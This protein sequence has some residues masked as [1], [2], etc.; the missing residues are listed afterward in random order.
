[1]TYRVEFVVENAGCSSCAERVRLALE[2]VAAVHEIEVDEAADVATVRAGAATDVSQDAVDRVLRE[3][4]DGAG[5]AYR[6]RPGS[7]RPVS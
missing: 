3:A 2:P 1:V 4:S 6:V 5:H 7:W